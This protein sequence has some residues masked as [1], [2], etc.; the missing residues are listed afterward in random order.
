[1]C[2]IDE[3]PELLLNSGIKKESK[4]KKVNIVK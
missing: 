2:R 3:A 1:M 4:P